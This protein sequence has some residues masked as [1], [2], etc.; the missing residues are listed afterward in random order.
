MYVAV[1]SGFAGHAAAKPEVKAAFRNELLHSALATEY[2]I[3]ACG[4]L[5][6]PDTVVLQ[7]YTVNS[8]TPILQHSNS[9]PDVPYT[10]IW[11]RFG[12]GQSTWKNVPRGTSTRSKVC[13]PK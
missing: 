7:E 12:S 4:P 8:I 9:L 5:N 2:W 11:G 10:A 3:D 1:L 13:A 6:K